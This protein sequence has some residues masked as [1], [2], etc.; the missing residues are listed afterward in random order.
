[1]YDRD[2]QIS[3]QEHGSLTN[4]EAIAQRWLSLLVERRPIEG[5]GNLGLGNLSVDQLNKLVDTLLRATQDVL[6]GN[7]ASISPLEGGTADAG[8]THASPTDVADEARRSDS[9]ELTLPQIVERHV[10]LHERYDQPFSLLKVSIEPNCSGN[11]DGEELTPPLATRLKDVVRRVDWVIRSGTDS[12]LLLPEADTATCASAKD[13][14]VAALAL[15]FDDAGMTGTLKVSSVVCP[16]DSVV[17]QELIEMV[18]ERLVEV[19]LP[20]AHSEQRPHLR[21]TA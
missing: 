16:D 17:A 12:Y 9:Y 10:L 20:E 19:S 18:D 14:V 8:H 13:R 4:S 21:L 7:E 2:P 6:P 5:L 11:A 15:E 3:D 1:M